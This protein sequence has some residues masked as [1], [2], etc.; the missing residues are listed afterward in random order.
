ME[1]IIAIGLSIWMFMMGVFSYMKLRSE[2][3]NEK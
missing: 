2:R 3:S 1:I